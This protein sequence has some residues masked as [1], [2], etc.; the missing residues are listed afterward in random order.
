MFFF[1]KSISKLNAYV[2]ILQL[3]AISCTVNE[4]SLCFVNMSYQSPLPIKV[5]D[6]DIANFYHHVFYIG[7]INPTYLDS[8]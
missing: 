4:T 6:M 3:K 5:L 2:F 8:Q 7:D 1:K